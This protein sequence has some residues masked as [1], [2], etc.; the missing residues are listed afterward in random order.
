M[1]RSLQ[2]RGQKPPQ[3]LVIFGKKDS[4]HGPPPETLARIFIKPNA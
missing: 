2:G 3:G 1:A 4:G